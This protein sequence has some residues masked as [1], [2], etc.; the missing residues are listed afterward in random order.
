M[1]SVPIGKVVSRCRTWNPKAEV[2]GTFDYIDLSSVDKDTKIISSTEKLSCTD[3][4]SRARQIVAKD[5]VLVSTVRPNLNGVALVEACHDGMTA[6]TGYCVL[7]PEPKKLHHRYL[8]HWVK[9]SIFVDCMVSVATGANYPA[10]SDAKVKS[11]TIPLPPLPE[12]K[13]IA[14]ILDA[15]DSLR[16]KRREA[17]SQ[18]D[19]LLQATFL[20]LFGDPVTNPKGWEVRPMATLASRVTK[21]ESPKWQGH[22]YQNSGALFVTSE[23]V[24]DGYLDISSPKYIPIEFHKKLSR[25]ALKG[26]DILIN[27]VGASIGRSCLYCEGPDQANINQAVAVVTLNREVEPIYVAAFLSSNCGKMLLLGNRV[28]GARANISLTNIRELPIPVP[29]LKDQR[30]F[31]SIVEKIESQKTKHRT[32][33]AELDTLFASLQDRAFTG[34]L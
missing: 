33:L 21:G 4:P 7:R 9:T 27:L 12:Q 31:A 25:S 22:E 30:H 13:R 32:H 6:S 5:D 10:V 28:E 26:Q 23:N 17:L 3:A 24:R 1:S 20:D 18:L 19:D 8:F 11:S 15:A 16:A 34:K 29:P 14:A 2:V